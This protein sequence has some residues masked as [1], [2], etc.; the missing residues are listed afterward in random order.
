MAVEIVFNSG[1][2]YVD[3]QEISVP[4]HD[5][6][7]IA[8]QGA[9]GIVFRARHRLLNRV[10]A[11]KIWIPKI[12]DRRDKITQGI[13]ETQSQAS[14][15]NAQVVS[16]LNTQVVDG[17][18]CASMEY[19]E[20]KSLKD[21]IKDAD[22]SFK[23]L[24]AMKYIMLIEQTSSRDLYHGDPHL[25]NIL[26]DDTGSLKLCDYGTSFFGNTESSWERH[27]KIVEEVT[28][29]LL[30]GFATYKIAE[31]EFSARFPDNSYKE[32]LNDLWNICGVIGSEVYMFSDGIDHLHH[33][34]RKILMPLLQSKKNADGSGAYDTSGSFRRLLARRRAENLPFEAVAIQHPCKT[35]GSEGADR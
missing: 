29:K 23:W 25:G 10:E 32:M 14:A 8:G 12:G 30:S 26:I 27:W 16:I 20:S 24:S 28:Q 5:L 6:I 22:L 7:D 3:G 9:N 1:S 17:Y 4:S 15:L 2:L 21:W 31:I 11:L 35:T 18:F 13:Y 33:D 19:F 34:Q